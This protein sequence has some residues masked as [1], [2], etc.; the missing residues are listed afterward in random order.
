M[1]NM[2]EFAVLDRQASEEWGRLLGKEVDG[3]V[4]LEISFYEAKRNTVQAI[5]Q[6]AALRVAK[7]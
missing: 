2:V 4:E 1:N 7:E 6:A 5:Q 3:I